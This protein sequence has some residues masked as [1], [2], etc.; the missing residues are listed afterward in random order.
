MLTLEGC[1]ERQRR[2][3]QCLADLHVDGA[4][5]SHPRDVYYLTGLWVEN[6]VFGFP[7]LLFIGPGRKS[8]LGT[9]QC[10]QDAAVDD[11]DTYPPGTL[12]TMNPDNH[13][14]LARL[15]EAAGT[16]QSTLHRIGFQAEGGPRMVL[17][18]FLATHPG[19]TLLSIDPVL[20]RQQLCKD[21]DEIACIRRAVAAAVAAYHTA[22]AIIAPG[23]NE[24]DVLAECTRAAFAVT[25]KPHYFGGDFRSA[26]R[27][28][29]A[30]NRTI[31]NGELYIID[32]QADVNGYWCDL[33]RVYYVG[34]SPTDLQQSVYERVANVLRAVP[35]MVRPG[36]SCT[37]FWHEIDRRLR[38]HP[39]LANTGLEHHGGH[40]VGLRAHEGPDINRDRHGVFAVGNVFTVEP[41]TYSPALNAGI[42][43]E[44]NFLL[45]PAGVEVLSELPLQLGRK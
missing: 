13:R 3:C 28:G 26:A 25:G 39:H 18:S 41:G 2:F 40:G 9:W 45:T 38:E 5:I 30:R 7:S 12:S 8:W 4:L 21:P 23:I 32:A 16:R 27:G 44:D 34:E 20:E 11:R 22:A 31:Q 6:P 36:R 37:E 35:Q 33:S 14:R 19:G 17:D 42:R 15:A 43:L 10:E 24:L 29:P 1:R